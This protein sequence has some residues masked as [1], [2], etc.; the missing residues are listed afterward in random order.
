MKKLLVVCFGSGL[1]L[2]AQA[3][4]V[5]V[6][7]GAV[8]VSGLGSVAMVDG[9]LR[10]AKPVTGAPYSAEAVNETI[11]TL[12][13]GNRIVN[14]SSSKIY[15]D[16]AGRER[17]EQSLPRIGPFSGDGT[18]PVTVMISDPVGKT[19]YTLESRG[20]N[21][22]R[23][24]TNSFFFTQDAPA[25]F[26][27]DAG[28]DHLMFFAGTGGGIGGGVGSGRGAGVVFA[29]EAKPK[30]EN[31]GKSVMEG[32]PVEGTRTTTTIPAGQIGN[33]LPIEVV[34]ER[35]YSPDLQVVV[36]SRHADPR[37]G[38]TVYKLMNINRVEPLPS[39][40]EVPSDYHVNDLGGGMNRRIEIHT[41]KKDDF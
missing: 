28:P 35:W 1:A 3:P 19:N 10:S 4:Q 34:S 24:A 18:A 16:S 26:S 5:L 6:Q 22:I 23:T 12:Y 30:T 7:N 31:L 38:E 39:L 15:R 33:D 29:E 37:M 25:P 32:V 40:F 20:K 11:Q 9:G 21:A 27:V 41:Q 13:D 36:Y 2:M 14:R 8:H 17:R